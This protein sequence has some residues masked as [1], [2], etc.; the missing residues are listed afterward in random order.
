MNIQEYFLK[1]RLKLKLVSAFRSG[2]LYLTYK[3]DTFIYPIVHNIEPG[4]EKIE[5]VFSIPMG[6][7]PAKVEKAFVFA[8]AFG[9]NIELERFNKKFVLTVHKTRLPQS[10]KYSYKDILP[11][12][13]NMKLP[14]IVGKS[15]HGW[16]VY[17]MLENPHL[18]IAGETGSGKSTQLRSIVPTLIQ[19]KKPE[20]L[21]IYMGDLKRSEFAMFRRVH[22]VKE[23]AMTT[24]HL[25]KILIHI[26][27]EMER[28]GDLLDTW[29][30]THI[31]DYNKVAEEKLPYIVVC[32]DEV[33]LLKKENKLMNII[34]DVS[35]IGRALGVF[36]ILS[37]QR[38]DADV[39]D[40][41]LKNNLT[42]RM[43]FRHSDAINSR[44][45]I[46]SGE[47]A[48]IKITERGRLYYKHE[49]L[50]QVQAPLLTAEKA[51]KILEPY[52]MRKE[53]YKDMGEAEQVNKKILGVLDDDS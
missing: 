52:R 42:V 29:E 5:F 3:K 32:I 19:F 35:A 23:V 12:I 24:K 6:L 47:A 13:E 4:K 38:P 22:H 50:K 49:E 33:A 20:E 1:R 26:R 39:L 8:Q 17:D 21:E 51:K 48:D 46:G 14:I 25:H 16:E 30:L 10:F 37:M 45:T 18:L 2:D 36:L 31:D 44:I 53:D 7:D 27:G 41:K 34:E 9:E 43:A 11:H 40:G 15:H 28:R